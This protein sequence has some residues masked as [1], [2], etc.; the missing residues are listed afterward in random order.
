MSAIQSDFIENTVNTDYTLR[1]NGF[2]HNVLSNS[3][4]NLTVKA[5][6]DNDPGNNQDYIFKILDKAIV[7]KDISNTTRYTNNIISNT[8]SIDTT[9]NGTL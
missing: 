4:I 9:P 1:F 2:T 5:N 8:A 7:G 6:V 3:Y